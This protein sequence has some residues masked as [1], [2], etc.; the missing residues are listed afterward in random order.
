[1][2]LN[3]TTVLRHLAMQEQM[4]VTV[5]LLPRLNWRCIISIWLA[6]LGSSFRVCPTT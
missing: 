4:T 3:I 5:Q 2:I 6:C 1:M